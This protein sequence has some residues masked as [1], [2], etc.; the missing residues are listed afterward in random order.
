MSIAIMITVI[1]HAMNAIGINHL[2][3]ASMLNTKQMSVPMPTPT[4]V[5]GM[6]A[7]IPKTILPPLKAI[8]L[9]FVKFLPSQPYHT[10][11]AL[12]HGLPTPPALHERNAK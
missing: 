5:A 2:D 9:T 8:Q 7:T 4:M 10:F 3:S 6:H 11:P 1:T 12:S